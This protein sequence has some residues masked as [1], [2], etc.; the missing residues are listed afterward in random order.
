[1][2]IKSH[3]GYQAAKDCLRCRLDFLKKINCH[4]NPDIYEQLLKSINRLQEKI[5]KYKVF[6]AGSQT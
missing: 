5:R 2:R 3:E 6:K 4:D 1:M